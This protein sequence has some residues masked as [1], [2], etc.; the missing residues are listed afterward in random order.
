MTQRIVL[1]AHTTKADLYREVARVFLRRATEQLHTG[2]NP[3]QAAM[4][5]ADYSQMAQVWAEQEQV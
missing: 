3:E 5:A 2:R 4:L 1:Q